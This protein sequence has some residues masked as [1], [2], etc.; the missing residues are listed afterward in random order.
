MQWNSASPLC[1]GPA[2]KYW[3]IQVFRT[4]CSADNSNN[5]PTLIL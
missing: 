3:G 5:F 2:D 1:Y 4:P